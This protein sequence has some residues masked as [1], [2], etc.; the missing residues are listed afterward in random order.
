MCPAH[1]A[2][3]SVRRMVERS[4]S[5]SLESAAQRAMEPRPLVTTGETF[6]GGHRRSLDGLRALAILL[7]VMIHAGVPFMR[8]GGIG[9]DLFFTLSGFLITSLLVGDLQAHGRILLRSFWVHR[10]IR[11]MP[12]LV[13]VVLT[14]LLLTQVAPDIADSSAVRREAL[15]AVTYT[16]NWTRAFGVT[17]DSLLNHTWSLAIEQQFYVVWPLILTCLARTLPDRRRLWVAVLISAIGFAL[18]RATLFW[19]EAANDRLYNGLDTRADSL[20]IG[21]VV[22]LA[23]SS[24]TYPWL[25]RQGRWTRMAVWPA[26]AMLGFMATSIHCHAPFMYLIGYFLAPCCAALIILAIV[27]NGETFWLSRILAV[28]PL[29]WIGRISYGLYLWHV[30]VFKVIRHLGFD[31]HVVITIG[32]GVS[33]GLAAVSFYTLESYF[34]RIRDRY[35]RDLRPRLGVA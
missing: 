27:M 28:A 7:V 33:I 10:A 18:W 14:V 1:Q 29:V 19:M 26:T 23:L 6:K 21:S 25:V 8:G 12:A 30:P 9:V 34:R 17:R 11:L 16:T 2:Q 31:G 5:R 24:C 13:V 3:E 35:D 15:A 4:G 20:L 22:A 32:L